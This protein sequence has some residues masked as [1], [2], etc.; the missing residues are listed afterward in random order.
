MTQIDTSARNPLMGHAIVYFGNDWYAENR[1]SSH[2]IALR[3]GKRTPLLYVSCPG[4]RSPNA[5]KR[6]I[7][8]AFNKIG[9]TG[10]LPVQIGDTMWTMTLP[11]IPFPGAPFV[12]QLNR[13]VG[14]ALMRRAIRHL[15][16]GKLISWF[17]VPHPGRFANSLGE[18]LSVYYCIDEY[19]A[20]PGVN[21][22]AIQALDD[23]LT[24]TCGVAFFC[25]KK[26]LEE[27]RHLRAE[28]IYSPHG[29]DADLFA[30]AMDPDLAVP[31][32]ARGLR[33]PVIGYFGNVTAWVDVE[34]MAEMARARPDW[35]FLVVG[36]A[37]VDVSALRAL[38][39]IIMTGPQKYAELPS[40]AKAF[41][42]CIAPHTTDS[43]MLNANP[44]KIREYLATG[45][46]VV[47]TWLPEIDM[48]SDVI[49]LVHDRAAFLPAIEDA[50]REGPDANRDKRLATVRATSWDA[51]VES[52][53]SSVGAA[54]AAKGNGSL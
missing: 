5:T 4:M 15:G 1:T 35:T 17:T 52:I 50:L 49:R 29:V 46:P 47:S 39:N 27:R 2:H 37:L 12:P 13:V 40:W 53:L 51:R 32:P 26:F 9:Q 36:L 48:F 21:K 54:L 23:Y 42:V 41:D 34:L 19:A 38:P 30:K 45:R 24:K 3:L 8:R 14:A 22:E 7:T 43:L 18:R 10:R 31:A 33:R 44:L 28:S 25:T 6:D 16:F 11:T 20:F